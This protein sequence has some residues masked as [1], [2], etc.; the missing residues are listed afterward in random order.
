MYPFRYERPTD[1]AEAVGLL[2]AHPQARPL[3]GGMTLVPTLKHRLARPSHL[4]DLT[5]LPGLRGV[6]LQ[7]GVLRIGA[8]TPHAQVA[9]SPVVGQAIPA[10]AELAGLIGDAQVRQRGT[11]GGSIA[12]N[13]PA[14]DYPSAVLA[15][16][17]TVV[18]DRR[19]IAADEFFTGMFS[20]ALQPGEIVTA[21]EFPLPLRAA[22][23]KHRH[24]ASGYALVGV[25]VADTPNERRV[26]VTGAAPCVFRWREAEAVRPSDARDPG[27]DALPPL[28]PE[29][30]NDDL[31]A[32]PAYR[33]H[34]ASLLLRRALVQLRASAA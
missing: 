8:A 16:G 2:Q 20:T 28:S 1:V 3:S 22:Y 31:A 19:R 25:F 11:L 26:A 9:A 34:L 23:C 18:T 17:A 30:L 29:G 21:V 4:V 33:A 7:D 13:D 24:P 12:N 10:L 27:A 15:L 32:T 14:A 6:E 5:R